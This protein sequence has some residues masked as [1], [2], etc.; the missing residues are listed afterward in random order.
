MKK[1][2]LFLLIS[3]STFSFSQSV[4]NTKWK[5]YSS[6]YTDTITLTFGTD[7]MHQNGSSLGFIVSSLYIQLGGD[8]VRFTD[9]GGNSALGCGPSDV[10]VY[11]AIGYTTDTFT[12]TLI[13]DECVN[14]GTSYD[15]VKFWNTFR[16]SPPTG[17]SNSV[18]EKHLISL[19]PN[20]SNGVFNMETNQKGQMNI[21]SISGDLI[22]SNQTIQV[23]VNLIEL[24][25]SILNGIY[26]V[27][28][29][30]NEGVVNKRVV[31]NRD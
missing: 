5:T 9:I 2:I 1:S 14:R 30:S 10:G 15:G 12:L 11:R 28:I 16:P 17:I 21:Y 24:P 31:I 7:S 25:Q 27:R 23:G 6:L 8:T 20:P 3:I 13:S 18:E 19:Y 29:L 26:F 4:E 22:L